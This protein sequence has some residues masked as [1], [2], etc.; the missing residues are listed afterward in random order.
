VTG[1]YWYD[2]YGGPTPRYTGD[3][4]RQR[5]GSVNGLAAFGGKTLATC[6]GGYILID[7]S[8]RRPLDDLP[9]YRARGHRLTGKPSIYGDRLY[10]SHRPSG[11]VS[12]VD[13]AD[14]KNPK[15]LDTFVTKGNPGRIVERRGAVIIPDGYHGLLVFDGAR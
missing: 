4:Y 5:I 3:N 13:I 8:E 15:A 7:R 11:E 6:R 12:I 10:L 1:L 9:I 2:L 14:P